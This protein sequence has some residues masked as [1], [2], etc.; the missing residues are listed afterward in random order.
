[1]AKTNTRK[2]SR[3]HRIP[4]YRRPWFVALILVVIL[5][6]VAYL[7]LR[8]V[9]PVEPISNDP[10][11]SS[12]STTAEPNP[13]AST[14]EPSTSEPV[15]DDEPE[16]T[17]QYEGEDPNLLGS[18][19]G[20]IARSSLSGDTLTIVAVIDQY[21]TR[22]GLCILTLRDSKGNQVYTASSDASAD[23][24]TSICDEFTVPVGTFPAGKYQIEIVVTGDDKQGKIK[25]EVSL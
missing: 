3:Y 18:L 10:P 9:N 14:T 21:L 12:P 17:L 8:A 11:V 22:P 23:I 25:G 13:P 4:V 20:S 1:M 7:V 15:P 16:K 19:T 24:T 6:L 2:S 5:A